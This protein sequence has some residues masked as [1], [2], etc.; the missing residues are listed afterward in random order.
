[1]HPSVGAAKPP[2]HPS[3]GAAKPPLHPSVGAAKPPLH[4]SVGAAKP[5]LH[6]PISAAKPT[7]AAS[8]GR[9]A[10]KHGR[11]ARHFALNG[12]AKIVAA[13]LVVTAVA[14]GTVYAATGS[15]PTKATALIT[16]STTPS[17]TGSRSRPASRRARWPV[18]RPRG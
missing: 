10:V 12:P 6:S 5:A 16:R 14:V 2:L 7:R 18:R 4:P 9:R 17:I 13:V 15:A 3:V 8:R 11:T 1:L